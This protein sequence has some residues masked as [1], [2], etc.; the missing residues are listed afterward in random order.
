MPQ[1]KQGGITVNKMVQV[2]IPETHQ[3]AGDRSARLDKE[4]TSHRHSRNEA[5]RAIKPEQPSTNA[6]PSNRGLKM[7]NHV[8]D[9]FKKR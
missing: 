1:M 5:L 2:P 9:V 4:V 8:H 3:A 6:L 7:A